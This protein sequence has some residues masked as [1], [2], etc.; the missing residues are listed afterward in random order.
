MSRPSP[1]PSHDGQ[2]LASVVIVNWNTKQLLRDCLESV[3][4]AARALPGAV[5]VVV[6]DNASTDGSDSLVRDEIGRA[7]V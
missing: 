6:V 4:A 3:D 1:L 5:E 2:T 7:H